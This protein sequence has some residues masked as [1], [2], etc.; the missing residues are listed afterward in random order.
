MKAVGLLSVTIGG[1]STVLW[2]DFVGFYQPFPTSP[3]K[4]ICSPHGVLSFL[5]LFSLL[6]FLLR[7]RD[8]SEDRLMDT[9]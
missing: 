8:P 1:A 9:F 3:R 2:C 4:R 7:A 6:L 5:V